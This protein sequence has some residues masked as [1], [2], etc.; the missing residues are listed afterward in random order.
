MLII[1]FFS[2]FCTSEEATRAFV[3]SDQLI[4]SPRFNTEYRFTTGEDYTHV[5]LINTAMPN[6]P[7]SL[8]K[9]RI[10]GTSAEPP[11]FLGITPQWVEYIQRTASVYYIGSTHGLSTPFK[12]SFGA[13]PWHCPIPATIPEKTGMMSIMVSFKKDAPGH[14]YRHEL[15][16]AVLSDPSLPIDIYGNGCAEYASYNDPR[17]KGS[18]EHNELYASYV[19]HISIENFSLSGYFSE[20]ISNA[21]LYGCTPV[22]LGCTQINT[23]FPEQVICLSGN[24]HHDMDLLRNI[25][26]KPDTYRKQIH[27]EQVRRQISVERL[28]DHFV[29]NETKANE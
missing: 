1:R 22:Y 17:I 25:C 5:I 24:L 13:M 11:Y 12:E 3:Q 15:V 19:F 28:I 7:S 4:N 20:K 27:L 16:R 26:E 14:R 6:L 2:N 8:P 18:F 29:S 21:L 10:I 9:H 23:Y